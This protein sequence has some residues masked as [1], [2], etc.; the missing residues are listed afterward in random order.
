MGGKGPRN[1]VHQL[2]VP[3]S[4][5]GEIAVLHHLGF[6]IGVNPS[7]GGSDADA[8]GRDDKVLARR[9]RLSPSSPGISPAGQDKSY[10]HDSRNQPPQE[11]TE[12]AAAGDSAK[13]RRGPVA[14]W[15]RV[16][17]IADLLIS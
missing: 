6:H 1:S 9:P 5:R 16:S 3:Q 4:Q 7:R 13:Q 11:Y 17:H 12:E 2:W 15:F 8:L 10:D 14:K